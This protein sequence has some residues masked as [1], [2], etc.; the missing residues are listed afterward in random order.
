MIAP[1]E[2]ERRTCPECTTPPSIKPMMTHR[3]WLAARRQ[4]GLE[5][6][7]TATM[8]AASDEDWRYVDIDFSLDDYRPMQ[9][10]ANDPLP[11]GDYLTKLGAVSGRVTMID[12]H[13]A[14]CESSE[15]SIGSLGSEEPSVACRS[16]RIRG[17]SRRRTFSRP[18]T[19]Q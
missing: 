12:G 2:S 16:I 4:K 15:L 8:P 3:E 19:T 11:E 14:A 7:A 13:V 6:W 9:G 17:R 1:S 10:L 18:P 5:A